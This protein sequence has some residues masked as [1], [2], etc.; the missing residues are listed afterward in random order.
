M[1]QGRG[2][3]YPGTFIYRHDGLPERCAMQHNTCL[4]LIGTLPHG[5]HDQ[6]AATLVY[7]GGLIRYPVYQCAADQGGITLALSL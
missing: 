1:D 2:Y 6:Q 5:N 3:S 7:P 4:Y